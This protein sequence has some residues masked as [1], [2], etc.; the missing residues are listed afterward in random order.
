MEYLRRSSH[1]VSCISV[2][3]VWVTKYRYHVLKG[4]VQRRCRDLLIQICDSENVRILKG[5]VSKDHVH[6]HIEYPPSLSV[7][8]LV[9][10]LKGR[11][12]HH[13]QHDYP[14]LRNRYWGQHFWAVGYGAWS[15]GNITDAMV[16][17]YLEHHNETPNAPS[18]NW[19]LEKD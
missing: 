19:I 1:T 17:E 8:M 5:V 11:T 14:E 13:L 16:Q 12:S 7:S 10:K 6:L 18:Q 9:K 15:T 2:H 3:L 4:D